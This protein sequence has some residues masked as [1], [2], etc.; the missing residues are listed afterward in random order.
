[1]PSLPAL[2]TH[3]GK[4]QLAIGDRSSSYIAHYLFFPITK[5]NL[6]D[7]LS[8]NWPA[9]RH[10]SQKA[11]THPCGVCPCSRGRT[12]TRQPWCTRANPD[13]SKTTPWSTSCEVGS[14]EQTSPQPSGTKAEAMVH[15]VLLSAGEHMLRWPA[16]WF[17]EEDGNQRWP[18]S[19]AGEVDSPCSRPRRGRETKG[20]GPVHRALLTCMGPAVI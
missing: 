12:M 7:L 8:R 11:C 2:T 18:T 15:A 19:S 5:P 14:S 17:R 3:G 10:T 13:D 4:C 20:A 9:A 1:M 16:L 6:V